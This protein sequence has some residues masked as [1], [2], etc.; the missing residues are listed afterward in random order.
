[1]Q[2]IEWQYMLKNNAFAYIARDA[3]GLPG[4]SYNPKAYTITRKTVTGKSSL[5]LRMAPC[6]GFAVSIREL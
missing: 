1:M 3:N 6:G 5:K 2:I 4:D